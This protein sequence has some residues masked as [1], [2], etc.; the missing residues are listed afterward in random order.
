MQSSTEAARHV[1]DLANPAS[2][3]GECSPW[4]V[5][6]ASYCRRH[7]VSWLLGLVLCCLGRLAL[8]HNLACFYELL[9]AY[10]QPGHVLENFER[11]CSALVCSEPTVSPRSVCTPTLL[12]RWLRASDGRTL[13]AAEEFF[14]AAARS[15]SGGTQNATPCVSLRFQKGHSS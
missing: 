13:V 10:Q 11:Q 14:F 2:V 1:I 5:N 12:P 15:P 4:I 8:A 3:W 9:P 7:K 6:D